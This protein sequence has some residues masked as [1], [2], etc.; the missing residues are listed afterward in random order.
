MI[1]HQ[2]KKIAKDCNACR[3][4][5]VKT[6][7][8]ERYGFEFVSVKSAYQFI[9]KSNKLKFQQGERLATDIK[10]LNWRVVVFARFEYV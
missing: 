3:W 8:P 2:L 6:E 4:W 1:P 5:Q 9:S 7:I 10:L